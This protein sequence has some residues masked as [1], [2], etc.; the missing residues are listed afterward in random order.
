MKLIALL[1][2]INV[3]GRVVKMDQLRSIVA[4]EGF[5]Q[6]ETFIA[7]GNVIVEGRASQAAKTELA[8]ERALARVLGYGVTAFVRTDDEIS[9]VSAHEPFDAAHV[10]R[11]A[12]FCVAFLKDQPDDQQVGRLMDLRSDAH[13]FHVR[14]REIFW[15]SRLNQ[16]DP[17]F[18]KVQLERIVG[19]PATVRGISTVRKLAAKY[20]VTPKGKK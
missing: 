20:P 5:S 9:D 12:T 16:S 2:A 8:I 13:D 4:A 6:V 3:G 18:A 17:L 19:G 15:L 11:A 7:S 10:A 1:R 14:G